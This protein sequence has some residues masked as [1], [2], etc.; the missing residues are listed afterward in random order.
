MKKRLV[1]ILVCAALAGCNE[2]NEQATTPAAG[3]KAYGY[4]EEISLGASGIGARPTGTEAETR[5]A[6]WIV[7]KLTGW[8][9]TPQLIPFTY[10]R[11]AQQM[12]SQNVEVVLPGQSDEML[13]IGAHYDS[14]GV[15]VGSE[16]ATDN[17]ASV[18]A[19]LATAE[20]L[21]GKKLP[22]TVRL[23]FFGAEENGVNGS[24]AYA[25]SLDAETLSRVRGMVNYD[26][27]VGGDIMYLHSAHSDVNEYNCSDPQKYSYSTQLRERL[28]AVAEQ[29]PGG[30]LSVHPAIPGYPAGET[31]SWS[32]H[33][34]FACLGIPI[35]YLEATNFNI[36]GQNG[37]DGYSQSTHPEL[38]DCFDAAANS[39][40]DRESEQQWGEIWHTGADRLDKLE[41]LFPGRIK[42]QLNA[43]T[44]LLIRFLTQPELTKA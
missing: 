25:A 16:G 20:A 3:S 34:S 9:Y 1:W 11:K 29:M 17:A 40:C 21:A 41:T 24:K 19:L 31:G 27:V 7:D 32:D 2:K 43:A 14:T 35:A 13:I 28:Q 12:Q 38:W 30:S 10:T 36:N 4:L 15:D 44:D 22:L 39:A 37:Y 18:A 42:Q 6:N 33:G 23:V 8:G 26:T 5:A